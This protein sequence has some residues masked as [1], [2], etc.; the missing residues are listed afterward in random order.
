MQIISGIYKN[1]TLKSP[2]SEKTH[3]MGSRE[4]LALMNSIFALSDIPLE[5]SNVL[6]AFAGTGALGLEALSR[7]AISV[8]FIEKDRKIALVLQ[9]NIKNVLRDDNLIK[10]QTKVHITPVESFISEVSYALIIA[11]P[12]YDAFDEEKL[13][14]LPKLLKTGGI[15]ALSMPRMK[16][17]PDFPGLIEISRKSYAAAAIVLYKKS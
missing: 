8:D 6:D 4:K 1:R 7:G 17:S 10:S 9:E 5:K 2:K 14:N 13:K 11:D 15:L 16:K 12:P 3:P